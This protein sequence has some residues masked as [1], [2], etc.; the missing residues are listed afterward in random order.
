[1]KLR[2]KEVRIVAPISKPDPNNEK[3][4]L[5]LRGFGSDKVNAA[6]KLVRGGT[7]YLDS[8][9]PEDKPMITRYTTTELLDEISRR[10]AH[11]A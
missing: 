4:E 5:V 10:T 2:L 11:Y 9:S 3:V 8:F 1:M 7:Y 6:L